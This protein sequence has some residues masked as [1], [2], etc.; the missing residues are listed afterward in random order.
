MMEQGGLSAQKTSDE[1]LEEAI[2]WLLAFSASS[3][4]PTLETRFKTWLVESE[5]HQAAWKQG[6]HVWEVMGHVPPAFAHV[7]ARQA[8]APERQTRP[9][10]RKSTNWVAAL[11]RTSVPALALAGIVFMV[12]PQILL[13][14]EADEITGTGEVRN[15]TLADGSSVVLGAKSAIKVSFSSEKRAV[16]LLTGEAYFDVTKDSKR[17]F[18]VEAHGVDVT[19]HGTAFD[20]RLASVT[21]TVALARGAVALS[22]RRGGQESEKDM[23]PGDEFTVDRGTGTLTARKI[24]LSDIASW[25]SGDLFVNS[26]RVADVVEELRRYEN[27]WINI[28]D[29][30]LASRRV[31]G[32]YDL[33]DPDRALRALVAPFGGKVHEITPYVRVV[34]RF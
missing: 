1:L 5:A 3:E 17:P 26:A 18:V 12:A 21:T 28:A 33:R 31:T 25:R 7:W 13:R 2:D 23:V 16:T 24:A 15:V 10:V 9:A 32:L 22:Y 27:G 11:I 4:D 30:E 19:V 34:A 20:V 6:L 29:P 14:L 8:V